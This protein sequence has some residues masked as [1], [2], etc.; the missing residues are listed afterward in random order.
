M[1]LIFFLKKKSGDSL[2]SEEITRHLIRFRRN[3][4]DTRLSEETRLERLL[5]CAEKMLILFSRINDVLDFFLK[6][7]Q[8]TSFFL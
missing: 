2:F 5:N 3:K 6:K 1:R 7:L 4:D 8:G